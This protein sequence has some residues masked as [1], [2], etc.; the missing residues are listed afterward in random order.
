MASNFTSF[1]LP[2]LPA[3]TLK[4]LPPLLPFISDAH[5]ALAAPIIAYWGVSLFFHI[6]DTYDL[7]P[8]FRLHTPAELLKRN[9]AT[10]FDVLK[11]VILQH[12][13]QTI[14]GLSLSF[15]DPPSM[16]GS[17]DYD[18][19]VWAQRIRLTQ[20]VIP[21][22]CGLF[23]VNSVALGQKL[24]GSSSLIAGV[25]AGGVYPQLN[26][27]VNFAG[28]QV[29]APASA[30]WEVHLAKFIYWI[31]IPAIQFIA[32]VVILDSWQYFLHRA[33]HMN[34]WLYSESIFQ[35]K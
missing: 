8:Q 3:Y 21:M 15:F 30:S 26:Q 2:P 25:F 17:E 19:A 11:D 12:I 33:M 16:Y 20:R 10:Q 7:L 28:E 4:P 32:A 34:H 6:I 9:P 13:I 29:V 18:V 27:V 31:A 24:G 23:G 5:L 1:S 35:S 14:A 22:L